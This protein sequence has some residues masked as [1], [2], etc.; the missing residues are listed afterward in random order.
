MKLPLVKIEPLIAGK[1]W[2]AKRRT[3]ESIRGQCGRRGTPRRLK[4][5][6]NIS[7]SAA[8]P[9]TMPAI[10]AR[11]RH[12]GASHKK[13]TVSTG[14]ARGAAAEIAKR[15]SAFSAAE[16]RAAIPLNNTTG[17]LR[18]TNLRV[19]LSFPALNPEPINGR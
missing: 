13:Q 7:I 2:A 11:P 18:P 5:N 15:L 3:L 9:Q 19:R 6:P 8:A 4:A 14:V 16:Q 17:A 10:K 12:E 1:N